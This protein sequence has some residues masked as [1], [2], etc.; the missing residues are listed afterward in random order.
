VAGTVA[1]EGR[2]QEEWGGYP[3]DPSSRRPAAGL[4]WQGMTGSH[5]K[6]MRDETGQYRAMNITNACC[7]APAED[8]GYMA[9]MKKGARSGGQAP[10]LGLLL[11]REGNPALCRWPRGLEEKCGHSAGTAYRQSASTCERAKSPQWIRV[12][13]FPFPGFR[14]QERWYG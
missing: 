10:L 11:R 13:S 9:A 2:K 8:E 5:M 6:M 3:L 12:I 14:Q 1:S 4:A 7:P